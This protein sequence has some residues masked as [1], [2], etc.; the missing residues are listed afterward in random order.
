MH[1]S[2]HVNPAA[3]K[4]RDRA[5][6]I[7]PST[8]R[9]SARHNLTAIRRRH[10]R[11]VRQALAHP[12]NLVCSCGDDKSDFCR[13]CDF[14]EPHYPISEHIDAVYSRRLGDKLGPVL[15]WASKEREKELARL[16]V[17]ALSSSQGADLLRRLRSELPDGVVGWHALSHVAWEVNPPSWWTNRITGRAPVQEKDLLEAVGYWALGRGLHRQLNQQVRKETGIRVLDEQTSAGLGVEFVPCPPGWV[18][19]FWTRWRPLAGVHD[20]A[21]WAHDVATTPG[22]SRARHIVKWAESRGWVTPSHL[23]GRSSQLI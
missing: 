17:L 7:L 16:G 22:P 11:E 14:I 5:R 2:R 15:R 23:A 21:A 10:R 9:T 3:A 1:T 19:H 12:Q 8:K 6:S 13:A 18:Q 4:R 20:V